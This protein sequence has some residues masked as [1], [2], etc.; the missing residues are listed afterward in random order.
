MFRR[1]RDLIRLPATLS[2]VLTH[3]QH[4]IALQQETNRRLA[5]LHMGLLQRASSIPPIPPLTIADL[6]TTPPPTP[7]RPVSRRPRTDA[8]IVVAS[9]EHLLD[10]QYKR[11][12]AAI[13]AAREGVPIT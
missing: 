5:E 3:V 13:A 8:D 2:H 10:E 6:T 11:E 9:R 12:A 4:L 7:A 1:L